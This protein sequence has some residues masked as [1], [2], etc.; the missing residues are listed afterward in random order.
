MAIHTLS[1][2]TAVDPI[3]VSLANRTPTSASLDARGTPT[4][5][6]GLHEV[7]VFV[8]KTPA[9]V[10]A[11]KPVDR[12]PKKRRAPLYLLKQYSTDALIAGGALTA[13]SLLLLPASGVSVV[14]GVI[15]G[16]VCL[17]AGAALKHYFY[18]TASRTNALAKTVGKLETEVTKLGENI[19]HLEETRRDLQ[20]TALSLEGTQT[21]MQTEVTRLQTQ[22]SSLNEEVLEAFDQLNVDRAKFEQEK[23]TLLRQL[24][25]EI[26]E[27]DER[28]DLAQAKLDRLHQRETKLHEL[29]TELETR[30][31]DLVADE[32]KLYSLQ[33]RLLAQL[34]NHFSWALK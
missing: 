19:D 30:R 25:D 8:P 6:L 5:A 32:A 16:V 24:A 7:D 10:S 13:I 20:T 31:K 29:K 1:N 2:L 3:A 21:Q 23:N 33:D 14:V 11:L 4:S 18:S 26:F 9:P 12:S 34:P 15:L 17:I 28:G 27:A 22:I